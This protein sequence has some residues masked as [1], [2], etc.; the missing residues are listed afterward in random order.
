M[1]EKINKEEYPEILT[2]WLNNH[3]VVKEDI[4]KPCSKLDYCPY[5][6]LV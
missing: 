2:K 4:E 6:Q 3:T 5:G 1:S